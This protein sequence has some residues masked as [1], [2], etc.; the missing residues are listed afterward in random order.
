ML[1]PQTLYSILDIPLQKYCSRNV[2]G[3]AKDGKN[4]QSQKDYE[5]REKILKIEEKEWEILSLIEWQ[6]MM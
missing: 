3:S 6:R 1:I 4:E 5:K 2:K